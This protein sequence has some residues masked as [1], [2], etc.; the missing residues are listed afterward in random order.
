MI[1]QRVNKHR[2][3]KINDATENYILQEIKELNE[4]ISKDKETPIH[5]HNDLYFTQEEVNTLL[6]NKSNLNHAHS[7][8]YYD[9]KEVVELI[10]GLINTNQA[11]DEIVISHVKPTN[12]PKI[13]FKLL[14]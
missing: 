6:S 14:D 3:I 8:L 10:N 4:A 1:L 11:E 13:W 5:N 9:K 2:T 7:N 12:N